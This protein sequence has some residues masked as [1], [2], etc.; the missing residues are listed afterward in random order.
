MRIVALIP[1]RA[2]SKRIPQKN[3]SPLGGRPLIAHTC[4]VAR[5]AGIFDAV[6]VNTDSRQIADVAEQYGAKCPLLRPP[7]LA[8]DDTSTELAT[9]FFLSYLAEHGETYD[10]LMILQPTS[11]LRSAADI[12][13]AAALYEENAPCTVVSVTH[14]A[15]AFWLGRGTK[16]GQFEALIGE[17]PLFKLNGAIYIFPFDSYLSGERP[18]RRM[19]YP[20]PLERSIDIDLPID[21][22][23]AEFFLQRTHAVMYDPV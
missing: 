21:L 4:E 11:P 14:V 17:E 10:A 23:L 8:Q 6:Y 16:D 20:M 2:G 19:L 13:E 3:L 22:E 12:E 7:A 15:P 5:A 9:R 18:T 1:A